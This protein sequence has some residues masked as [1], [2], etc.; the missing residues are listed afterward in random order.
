MIA[1][2]GG[3]SIG[4]ASTPRSPV[5]CCPTSP[6]EVFNYLVEGPMRDPASLNKPST[7][8]I[9]EARRCIGNMFGS[10]VHWGLAFGIVACVIAYVPD[11]S[12]DLRLCRADGGGNLRAAQAA[13]L[14]VGRLIF[15]TCLL[16]GAAAGLA[17]MVE[18]AAV[19]RQ[20]N[21][22]LIAGYGFTGILVSFIARHH[23]L[24]HH[25]GGHTVRRTERVQR[26]CSVACTVP[27]ASVQRAHGDHLRHDLAVR[28]PLRPLPRLHAAP[29]RGRRQPHERHPL[30]LD[31]GPCRW[32]SSAAPIRVGTPFLFVSL[33]EC[34]TEKAGRV[35]LGLEGTLVMG[36]MA[37][38][39]SATAD[40]RLGMT[41]ARSLAGRP[42]GGRRRRASWACCTPSSATGRA[43]I[44]LPSASP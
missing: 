27:D 7:Y 4:A 3:L 11:G 41:A 33:G 30:T 34:I 23:P 26:V 43:S 14:P 9:A 29:S 38:F 19:Q 17:G 5:C 13:G 36:A 35:N 22:S 25:S 32:P 2:V 12:H 37:A 24:A 8:P 18:I 39:A 42:G 44:P 40:E 20:A 10:D 21:A 15:T 31:F 28:D 16:G 1:L 6:S